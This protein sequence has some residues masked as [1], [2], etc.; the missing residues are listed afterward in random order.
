MNVAIRCYKVEKGTSPIRVNLPIL[1]TKIGYFFWGFRQFPVLG[2]SRPSSCESR[3]CHG[4]KYPLL[5]ERSYRKTPFFIGKSSINW[6]FSIAMLVYQ[7]VPKKN[8]SYWESMAIMGVIQSFFGIAWAI[9][10]NMKKNSKF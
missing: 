6:P 7:R 3:Q 8:I 1:P 10:Q 4:Q 5:N 9:L 2:F